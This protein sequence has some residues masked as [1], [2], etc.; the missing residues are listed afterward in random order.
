MT[1]LAALLNQESPHIM[2]FPVAA[3]TASAAVAAVG[4]NLILPS[5][6]I[7]AAD[8]KTPYSDATQVGREKD[9]K[10]EREREKERESLLLFC[11]SNVRH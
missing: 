6:T 5:M 3:T 9:R 8:T 11:S 4:K 7:D 2:L 10:R 1:E